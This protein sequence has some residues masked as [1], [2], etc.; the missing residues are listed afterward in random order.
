[1]E[2]LKRLYYTHL[3]KKKAK[4]FTPHVKKSKRSFWGNVILGLFLLVMAVAFFF[5]VVSMV[6]QSLKP[7]NEMFIFTPKIII[8]IS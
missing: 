8:A 5:P 4:D 1:M 2:T 6:S 7:M 3:N